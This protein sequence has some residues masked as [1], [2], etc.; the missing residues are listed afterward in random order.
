MI[1]SLFAGKRYALVIGNTYSDLISKDSELDRL[2]TCK[3]D[4]EAVENILRG[5]DFDVTLKI[6]KSLDEMN[7]AF[8]EFLNKLD[9]ESVAV[10]YFSGHGCEYKGRPFYFPCQWKSGPPQDILNTG[11]DC[12]NARNKINNKVSIGLKMILPTQVR[13]KRITKTLL[14]HLPDL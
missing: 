12:H 10:F 5:C 3:N 6:D 2:P 4:A 8:N 13:T 9:M 7:T 1:E 11:F 14:G